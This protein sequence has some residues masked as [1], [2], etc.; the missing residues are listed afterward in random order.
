M[1][2]S[3]IRR[4]NSRNMYANINLVHITLINNIS[5]DILEHGLDCSAVTRNERDFHLFVEIVHL[6]LNAQGFSWVERIVVVF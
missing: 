2:I 1:S 6:E 3:C 4:E 5:H